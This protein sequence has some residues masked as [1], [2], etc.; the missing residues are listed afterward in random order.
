MWVLLVFKVQTRLVPWWTNVWSFEPPFWVMSG[1]R[2]AHGICQLSFLKKSL[3]TFTTTYRGVWSWVLT[4]HLLTTSLISAGS[5][6]A[7]DIRRSRRPFPCSRHV[8]IYKHIT[9]QWRSTHLSNQADC[10]A[11]SGE[12]SFS[13]FY[14]ALSWAPPECRHLRLGRLS[15]PNL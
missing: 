2:M 3:L 8:L 6:T 14:A 5:A 12:Q 1:L 9:H 4:V 7:V 13:A 15:F 10:L 11:V